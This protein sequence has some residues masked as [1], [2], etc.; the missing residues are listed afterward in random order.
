MSKRD[1]YDVLGVSRSASADEIKKAY[2]KLAIKY[3]PDK[4]PG[5]KEAEENF[6]EAAEAYDVLSNTEKKQRYDQFGHAGMGGGGGYGGGGFSMDDI[7]SQFGDI[8]GDGDVFGS[9]F[10]GGGG[11]GGSRRSVGS[12][13]RIKLKLTLSEMKAGVEKKVKYRRMVEAD[14]VKYGTCKQCNGQGSVR[15]VTN[16]FLGQMATSSPCPVCN[17]LGKMVESKPKDANEQ[18]LISQEVETSIRI[19][20]GVAEGMQLSMNGKGNAGP[21]GG[22]AGD[23]IVLIE[24]IEHEDLTRDGNNVLYNLWL[25]FPQA[26]LGDSV[27]VPTL[28]GK[29]RI[30]ID[31]GTQAGKVLRLKGK[32]FPEINGYGTGDQLVVVNVFVPTKL[33]SEEKAMMEKFLNAENFK[34]NDKEKSFFD[35]MKDFFS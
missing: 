5:D 31:A 1:F 6:K 23:L 3:H 33:N 29:V 2:R 14:G 24:G 27:E 10:G 21:G 20:G 19:P 30:K 16:T 22:S 12:N 18:G 4:N 7:F 8:F 26:A 17:G 13:I 35:K 25:S 28:E 11:R 34:P 15:R 9:F 32:G